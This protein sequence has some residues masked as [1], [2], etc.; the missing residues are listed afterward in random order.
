MTRSKR[1]IKR[2]MD[3]VVS[4]ALLVSLSPVL[5][6]V[7]G[8]VVAALGRPILFR[9]TRPGRGG[10]PFE[11]LKFRTMTDARNERGALLPDAERLTP[12][13]RWLR[14]TSL[15]ELPGL[16]NVLRGDMSLVGPRP[17]LVSYLPLYSARQARRHDVR[18][19]M[20]GWAQVNGRNALSW[21]EKFELD[22]WYVDNQSLHLDLEIL[23][24]TV[25]IVVAQRGISH[26]GSV[27]MP[28]FTGTADRASRYG[29]GRGDAN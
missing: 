13:G 11:L 10:V 14:A 24:R 2:G 1:A 12:L 4:A 26:A 16:V 28:R 3:I 23:A 5:L 6:I 17:L 25:W 7:A 29:K 15:D 9:H 18:P 21:D 27:T 19:G 22:I 8:V 20:T